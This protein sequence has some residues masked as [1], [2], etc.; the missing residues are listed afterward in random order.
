MLF[1]W[2]VAPI[3]SFMGAVLGLLPTST[4]SPSLSGGGA[5]SDLGSYLM[6]ANDYVD[7]ATIGELLTV[8]VLFIMPAMLI[9]AIA[10]WGYRELPDLWG[11]GPS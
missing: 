6:P 11:F 1:D 10:Q 2:L 5:A 7:V 9:Y 8:T 3:V 4:W